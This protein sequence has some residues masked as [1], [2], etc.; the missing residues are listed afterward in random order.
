MRMKSATAT[1]V[2]AAVA[3]GMTAA[4][5]GAAPAPAPQASGVHYAVTRDGDSAV[6]TLDGGK[7]EQVDSQLLIRDAADQP[8]A[9]I[10]L[11][12]QLD[13]MAYPIA[14]RIDGAT[15]ILTPARAGGQPVAAT[16]RA[17]VISVDQAATQVAESFVPR[18]AQALGVFAQRAAIGA[19]VSAVVG[20]VIGGGIGCL[21]GA[22]AGAVLSSPLIALLAPVVGATIAGC[23]VGATTMG[24]VGT[25]AGLLLAGGP[26]VLF[27]AIQYFSTILAPCPP[28][29]AQCKDPAAIPA[30]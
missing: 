9:A 13:D 2:F 14:A 28:E 5:A 11:Q 7:I 1:A 22:G 26:I 30:K 27:S 15:A 4:T 17:E 10:P 21:L 18:D 19:A 20:A 29:Q 12:Y 24:A 6:V 25:L 23:V 8:L 3:V 16:E